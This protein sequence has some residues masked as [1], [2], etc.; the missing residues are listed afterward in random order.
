MQEENS[1]RDKNFLVSIA[2]IESIFADFIPFITTL[3]N[4]F[5]NLNT[6]CY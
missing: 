2:R 5:I 1:K 4:I 3:F 6:F